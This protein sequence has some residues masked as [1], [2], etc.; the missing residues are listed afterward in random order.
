MLDD[1]CAA[2]GAKRLLWGADITLCTGLSKLWALELIGLTTEELEDVRWGNA[3][4]IFRR[5]PTP[6]R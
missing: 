5:I 6:D 1:A 3:A 2:V 4:R